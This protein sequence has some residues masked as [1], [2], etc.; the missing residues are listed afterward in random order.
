MI[1]QYF[2]LLLILCTCTIPAA[3][4]AGDP[5][6]SLFMFQHK[7]AKNGSSAAMMKT[8]EMY[9]RGEGV[10]KNYDNALMMYKKAKDAGNSQAEKAIQR[11]NNAKNK[12]KRNIKLDDKKREKALA[13][14]K[15]KK[16]K[17]IAARARAAKLKANEE[18]AAKAKAAAVKNK[19]LE[20]KAAAIAN[21][22]AVKAK[23]VRL[24]EAKLREKV[25]KDK[26]EKDKAIKI[27]AAKAKAAAARIKAAQRRKSK[28]NTKNEAFKSD[29]CKGKAARLLSIC[30]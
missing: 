13:D 14:E 20:Q 29:P 1:K 23:A 26:A 5:M 3:F 27:K 16:K 22:N 15:L 2:L 11:L 28:E 12:S 17:E 6:K 25:Q 21:K 18:K 7:M 30:R 8:G 24:K 9:E 19:V 4:S 10:K